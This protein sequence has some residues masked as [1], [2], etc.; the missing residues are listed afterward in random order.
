MKQDRKHPKVGTVAAGLSV[1]FGWNN[2]LIHQLRRLLREL[3]RM[4]EPFITFGDF[5]LPRAVKGVKTRPY[6]LISR[7]LDD[8]FESDKTPSWPASSSQTFEGYPE[9]KIDHA[10]SR[11]FEVRAAEVLPL[12]GSDHYPFML[13]A[14]RADAL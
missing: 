10:F 14:E 5:N 6:R 4:T 11:G 8:A 7:D 12:R 9:M 3:D 1:V 13:I 2:P